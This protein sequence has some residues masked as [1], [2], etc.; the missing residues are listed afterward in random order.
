MKIKRAALLAWQFTRRDARTGVWRMM[1][2]TL[3]LA[4]CVAIGVGLF[5]QRLS[6][7]LDT[8]AA[9]MIGGDLALESDHPIDPAWRS[10]AQALGLTATYGVS[11][12]S[13]MLA[14]DGR[15]QLV[16]VHTLD[17]HYPLLGHLDIEAGQTA[18]LQQGHV[19]LSGRL[20]V[21]PDLLDRLGVQ[22]GDAVG[23][24]K[25]HLTLEAKIVQ[26]PDK[27]LSFI[28]LGPNVFI[29]EQDLPASGLLQTASRATY[30]LA[31]TGK[32]SNLDAW[33][34][35]VR[36]QLVRGQK[37]EVAAK[38]DSVPGS[39]VRADFEQFLKLTAGV[40]V[41]ICAMALGLATARYVQ[42]RQ[43]TVV[44]LR[45]LGAR[46][47]DVAWVLAWQGVFLLMLA[48]LLGLLGGTVFDHVFEWVVSSWLSLPQTGLAWQ[49]IWPALLGASLLVSVSSV[50]PILASLNAPVLTVLRANARL[51]TWRGWLRHAAWRVP[52]I[53]LVLYL[54][55]WW[56][57]QNAW[58]AARVLLE[59]SVGVAL[60]LGAV[61][62][63]VFV[64]LRWLRQRSGTWWAPLRF[65]IVSLGRRRLSV[66][67]QIMSLTIG[68]FCLTLL[69]M[70]R[71]DFV[72]QWRTHLAPDAPNHFL[73]NI[74]PE[75]I[76]ELQRD[77]Q[78]GGITGGTFSTMIRGRLIAVDGQSLHP[79][80][81][82]DER[83]RGM[84]EREFNLSPSAQLPEGNVVV[85]GQWHGTH[86]GQ[87][88]MEE[89]I[90]NRLNLH[91]GQSLTFEIAGEPVT[92]RLSSIRRLNWDSMQVNFFAIF[93]PE[94]LEGQSGT[95]ITAIHVNPEQ[96]MAIVNAVHHMPNMTDIDVGQALNQVQAVI[97]QLVAAV[98][99][100]FVFA[101]AAG[102]L[103]LIAA[104]MA[105]EDERRREMALLR[106][107]GASKN[108][109]T[110]LMQLETASIGVLASVL[111]CAGASVVL[112]QLAQRVFAFSFQIDWLLVCGT[113][114]LGALTALGAG[115]LAL[116]HILRRPPA[117]YLR[118]LS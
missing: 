11:F 52:P 48:F 24:G 13:M 50:P 74:E 88:S 26:Q 118:A 47:R 80:N 14:A 53:T 81:F 49:A 98:Q 28:N 17:A 60:L 82:A 111:A 61:F 30:R 62:V 100:L 21:E 40:T 41:L 4:V 113:V 46:R 8:Y 101:V 68:I 19:P 36:P 39:S 1:L 114:V 25:L 75:Q 104:L 109:L 105:T 79:E 51:Q 38:A 5:V 59:G 94:L 7:H 66:T 64:P 16:M 37:L 78:Q 18:G 44:V 32:V 6:Q 107:L 71:F 33:Q 10:H 102:A 58:Q 99:F 3:T 29:N 15:M 54:V 45:C 97:A 20:W 43:D 108:R 2:L 77:L 89:G 96:K 85:A 22:V 65:A 116:G 95:A 86:P 72:S 76:P 63:L 67:V 57:T 69:A 106:T 55:A 23:L 12:P 110:R 90:A 112:W 70:V 117:E 93:S 73:I 87:M 84:L 103:V 34:A 27:Q 31:L 42:L 115:W 83:T 91:I 56:A 92:A 35:Y 9:Q